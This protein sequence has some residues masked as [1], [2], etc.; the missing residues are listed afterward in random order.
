MAGNDRCLD[1]CCRC[2]DS[3]S[4]LSNR[5]ASSD[6]AALR[7]TSGHLHN[8]FLSSL[9]GFSH[10]AS[11]LCLPHPGFRCS[12]SRFNPPLLQSAVCISVPAAHSPVSITGAVA[13]AASTSQSV[14]P[15]PG[16][17]RPTDDSA[18]NP[19]SP[20][21]VSQDTFSCCGWCI[22]RS[23]IENS[24]TP[25]PDRRSRFL[26]TQREL[27]YLDCIFPRFS[28][29]FPS[30]AMAPLGGGRMG[31]SLRTLCTDTEPSHGIS[32]TSSAI[33]ES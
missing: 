22:F 6:P 27:L 7:F 11:A 1:R 16:T 3:V 19:P 13:S 10:P 20:G 26:D 18:V 30:G 33:T 28:A 24:C 29:L 23:D 32:R 5:G 12:S 9:P 17:G 2:G 8:W 4:A 14:A 31:D 15:A 25:P 21:R